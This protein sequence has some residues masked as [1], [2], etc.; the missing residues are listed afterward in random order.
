MVRRQSAIWPR[1]STIVR[2]EAI[3]RTGSFKAAMARLALGGGKAV[4]IGDPRERTDDQLRAFG[5]FVDTLAGFYITAADMGTGEHEMAVIAEA[6]T[7]EM[8]ERWAGFACV[9]RVML[10]NMTPDQIRDAVARIRKAREGVTIEA[11]GGVT[12]ESA[13]ALQGSGVDAVSVGALT[14]S[15]PS[16]DIGLD[17]T[18]I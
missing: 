7:P 3:G 9:R 4:V 15:V 6:T 18:G 10:D 11:T 17:L 1:I 12:L 2:R 14:H 8:A 13:A 5:A 16:I